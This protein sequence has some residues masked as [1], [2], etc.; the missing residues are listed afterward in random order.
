MSDIRINTLEDFENEI[1]RDLVYFT[2]AYL[3]RIYPGYLWCVRLLATGMIGF[4]L[5]ELIQFG[6][7]HVMVVHPKD[8][9]T[10]RAFEK[11]VKKLGGELLE[12]AKLSREGS[13]NEAVLVRPD[14]FNARFDETIRQTKFQ[15]KDNDGRIITR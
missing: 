5:G 11:I 6:D 12:R 9:P 2:G 14:G 13:K 10:M 7:N 4:S 15:L 8:T 3:Q 1:D